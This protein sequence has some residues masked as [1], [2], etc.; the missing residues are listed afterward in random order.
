M[1][2]MH[3]PV[4]Q[5]RGARL[6]VAV[7]VLV[8]ALALSATALAARGYRVT[9]AAWH[10]PPSSSLFS[11]NAHGVAAHKALLYVYLDR[12]PCQGTWAS[13]ANRFTSFKAGQSYFRNTGRAFVTLWVSGHFNKSFTAHAGTTARPEYACAYLTTSNSQGH[14]KITAAHDSNAYFVTN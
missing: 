5:K 3:D 2:T 8:L 14:Y 13:E 7:L 4:A 10:R 1:N 12:Q 11:V 9:D 6:A